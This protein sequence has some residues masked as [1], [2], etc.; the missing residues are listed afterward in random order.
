MQVSPFDWTKPSQTSLSCCKWV[1]APLMRL[2][3]YNEKKTCGLQFI[4]Y[5]GLNEPSLAPHFKWTNN[6]FKLFLRLA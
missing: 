6:T 5:I 1:Y 4:T 3:H 2:Y